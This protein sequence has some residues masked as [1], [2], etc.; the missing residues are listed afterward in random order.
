MIVAMVGDGI[1]DSLA[2]VAAD[3]G[4]EIGAGTNI[5]IETVVLFFMKEHDRAMEL[6]RKVS[7]MMKTTKNYQK[8]F[9]YVLRKLT[10]PEGKG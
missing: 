9:R 6:I 4:M 3:V 10:K 8:V 5:A 1:N 7:N 2:L